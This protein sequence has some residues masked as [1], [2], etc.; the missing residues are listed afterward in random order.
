MLGHLPWDRILKSAALALCVGAMSTACAKTVDGRVNSGKDAKYKGAKEIKFEGTEARARGIVPYP[1][2]DREDWKFLQ[3]PEGKTGNLEIKVRYK[4]PRP[5]MDVAFD[6]F[7]EYYHRVARAKPDKRGRKKSKTIKISGAEG[8]YFVQIYAPR[9]M[10]AG[11]YTV[12]VDFKER[13]Q[14]AQVDPQDIVENEIADPP[15]L[16]AVPEPPPPEDPAAA[17]DK[18]PEPVP[19][20]PVPDPNANTDPDPPPEVLKPVKGKVVNIQKSTAGSLIITIN[21]GKKDG[22]DRGWGGGVL[23]GDTDDFLD[24]GDFQVIKVTSKESVAKVKMSYDQQSSNRN[25]RLTPP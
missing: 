23:A 7:D 14:I 6:V 3:L 13:K 5:G 2:G 24:G 11:K 15:T 25:V 22:V 20:V 19:P 8:K 16:P 4:T 18:P 9:R 17:G 1:G 21:K 12:E 10:D